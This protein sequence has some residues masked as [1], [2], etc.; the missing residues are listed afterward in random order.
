LAQQKFPHS[1]DHFNAQQTINSV[2]TYYGTTDL[3]IHASILLGIGAQRASMVGASSD[4][5]NNVEMAA[6]AASAIE[7]IDGSV[8]GDRKSLAA[9]LVSKKPMTVDAVLDVFEDWNAQRA[10]H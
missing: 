6:L 10:P 1:V 8:V 7:S 9:T 3:R 5:I 4:R 2:L